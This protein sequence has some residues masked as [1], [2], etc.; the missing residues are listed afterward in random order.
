MN[1]LNKVGISVSVLSL[2]VI[3]GSLYYY[4]ETLS[5]NSQA[6]VETQKEKK[7][8]YKVDTNNIKVDTTVE[9][10]ILVITLENVAN[11]E[12]NDVVLEV[13]FKGVK[14][15]DIYLEKFAVGKKTIKVPLSNISNVP[16][17][18]DNDTIVNDFRLSEEYKFKVGEDEGYILV[19]SFKKESKDFYKEKIKNSDI[20]D[21]NKNKVIKALDSD[22]EYEKLESYLKKS[23]IIKPLSLSEEIVKFNSDED[24]FVIEAKSQEVSPNSEVLGVNQSQADQV[25]AQPAPVQPVAPVQPAPVQPTPPVVA[26]PAPVQPVAPIAGEGN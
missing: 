19:T 22:I 9:E 13:V 6:V 8:E 16:L 24:N 7:I 4:N 2:L 15:T 5:E 12:L 20:S 11:R 18:K 3:G 21:E 26:Q 17:I 23:G 10:N 1:L 25:V 14:I